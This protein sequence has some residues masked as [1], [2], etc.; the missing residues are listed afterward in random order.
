MEI[1]LDDKAFRYWNVDTHRWEIEPGSYQL[2]LGASCEDIRLSA[3][4][5][6]AGS[7]AAAPYKGLDL[8]H[9]RSGQV[10]GMAAEEF[11]ALR[12]DT[13][14]EGKP[15][16]DRNITF[17]ELG[18]GRSPL[19]WLVGAVLNAKLRRSL[20]SGKPDLNILFIYNMPLR[21]VA[22]MTNGMVSMG[23]VDGLVMEL[24]GFWV[25]GL[26]RALGAFVV[27]LLRNRSMEKRLR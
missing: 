19:G 22:K 7:G 20:R 27:N 25:L 12:G 4:I 9:Y 6:L 1:P 21:A 16:I 3:D 5:V 13:R 15:A 11:D 8:P 18:H 26:L 14:R 2:R 10:Q 24:K 23:V 17:G